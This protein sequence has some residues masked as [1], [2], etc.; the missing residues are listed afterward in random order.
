MRAFQFDL[1][2]VIVA[3]LV[4][5]LDYFDIFKFYFVSFVLFILL[6]PEAYPVFSMFHRFD[7]KSFE[8][9]VSVYKYSF[10]FLFKFLYQMFL[11]KNYRDV[12]LIIK[13]VSMK[14]VILKQA[15]A[16]FFFLIV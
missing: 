3:D 14:D 2:L 7:F 4:V 11:L 15:V 5:F 9:T 8:L 1:Q 6:H 12:H 10:L 13:M 16:T